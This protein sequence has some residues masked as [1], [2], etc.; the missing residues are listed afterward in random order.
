MAHPLLSAL[1]LEISPGAY[2]AAGW[3]ALVVALFCLLAGAPIMAK[4]WLKT[5]VQTKPAEPAAEEKA[6]QPEG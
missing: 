2:E 3:G 4:F 6:P 1:S 5:P